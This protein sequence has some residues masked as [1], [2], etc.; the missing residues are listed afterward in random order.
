LKKLNGL[1]MEHAKALCLENVKAFYENLTSLY[2]KNN[3]NSS[4]M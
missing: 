4:Q 2:N 3:Y 1:E